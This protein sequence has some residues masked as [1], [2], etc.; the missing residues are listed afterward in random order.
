MVHSL[1]ARVFDGP[2][3]CVRLDALERFDDAGRPHVEEDVA[4]TANLNCDY[5]GDNGQPGRI[6]SGQWHRRPNEDRRFWVHGES[7]NE[8]RPL[9]NP[10]F[11]LGENYLQD[12]N[13]EVLRQLESAAS[14]QERSRLLEELHQRLLRTSSAE[15]WPHLCEVMETLGRMLGDTNFK[16]TLTTLY[17]ICDLS[18]RWSLSMVTVVGAIVPGL[19]E[20][21][22]DNKIVVRQTSVKTFR[23]MFRAVVKANSH[24]CA[25]RLLHSLTAGLAQ[26][27]AL[28]RL[29]LLGVVTIALLVFEQGS[30]PY[31]REQVAMA[32]CRAAQ[33]ENEQVVAA[34]LEALAVLL[35]AAP[36]APDLRAKVNA[37]LQGNQNTLE[38]LE[39]RL[40]GSTLP[41]LADE[42]LLEYP[43]CQLPRLAAR[44][45]TEQL[46]GSAGVAFT[47][48]AG[49][50]RPV[51]PTGL[52]N[53]AVVVGR[54]GKKMS[55]LEETPSASGQPTGSS[56]N[57]RRPSVTNSV[58]NSN[59]GAQ[60]PRPGA[61]L[62]RTGSAMMTPTTL[63]A[64]QKPS[65][66]SPGSDKSP[67]QASHGLEQRQQGLPAR[68]NSGTSSSSSSRRERTDQ[69][70]GDR[71]GRSRP[72]LSTPP[73][74]ED[75][76]ESRQPVM[77]SKPAPLVSSL[78]DK[79]R[80]MPPTLHVNFKEALK[81][82]SGQDLGSYMPNWG[83]PISGTRQVRGALCGDRA[84]TAVAAAA[85]RLK[86]CGAASLSLGLKSEE[87]P[88]VSPS[89]IR[90]KILLPETQEE[91]LPPLQRR[92]GTKGRDASDA[93]MIP[94]DIAE[95]LRLLK[96][97]AGRARSRRSRPTASPHCCP[98]AAPLDLGLGFTLGLNLNV[99]GVPTKE[100]SLPGSSS[101]G[102][103]CFGVE[104]ASAPLAGIV[105]GAVHPADG[106][107]PAVSA[108]ALRPKAARPRGIGCLPSGLPLLLDHEDSSNGGDLPSPA[109]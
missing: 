59:N 82:D 36:D 58:S 83:R 50:V 63:N 75:K 68:P 1:A 3:Q 51:S 76:E 44:P 95:K 70:L 32:M 87:L 40:D 62:A 80:A 106:E 103:F 97:P 31:D 15:S 74:H 9:A 56:G 22:G 5:L 88:S 43:T 99:G 91:S 29:E 78:R 45:G 21:L 28:V 81:D 24:H 19:I 94:A 33:D 23:A 55:G 73:M 72:A 34:A 69:R 93:W 77:Q 61:A 2:E 57:S 98:L 14:W 108:R 12:F 4:T 42:G 107:S 53:A 13:P 79:R 41:S 67:V 102:Q 49:Y 101:P 71:V 100:T 85:G 105:R 86:D 89:A 39:A 6:H 109:V 37:S 48:A 96:R 46:P 17:I 84:Q 10:S 30:I 104:E 90:R 16:I 35:S 25:G 52:P 18:E 92:P 47:E 65:P 60:Q 64:W 66:G 20:K 38:Q 7:C 54:L 26:R 27:S 8:E 11:P